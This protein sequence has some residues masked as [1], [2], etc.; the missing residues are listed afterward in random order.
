MSAALGE[1]MIE[2]NPAETQP[3][4]KAVHFAPAIGIRGRSKLVSYLAFLGDETIVTSFNNEDY[5]AQTGASIN[6]YKALFNIEEQ[7]FKIV[8]EKSNIPTLI[9]IHPDDML[10]SSSDLKK[11]IQDG[12]RTEWQVD[13]IDNSKSILPRT[14]NHLI[15]DEPSLGTAEWK[16]VSEKLISFLTHD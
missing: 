14:W 6:A 4:K 2:L 3:F 15:I 13:D 10:I 8:S 16:R 12:K 9:F 11:F 7:Y 1:W 5:K